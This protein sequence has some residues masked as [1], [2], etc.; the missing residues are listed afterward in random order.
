MVETNRYYILNYFSAPLTNPVQSASIKEPANQP[1]WWT[2]PW[3]N[4]LPLPMHA[5]TLFLL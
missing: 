5:E 1:G 4:V 2:V 3:V